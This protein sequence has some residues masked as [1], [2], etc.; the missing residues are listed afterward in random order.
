MTIL[1]ALR[2]PLLAMPFIGLAATL[3]WAA[4]PDADAIKV[5]QV[6]FLPGAVKFAVVPDGQ[7]RNFT[8]VRAGTDT[9]A[10][11][12]TLGPATAHA[13]SG[14][15]VR[16][17]P[18]TALAAPGRYQVRV[19]E[20]P[21]SA[22]FEIGPAVYGVVN[23][24]S[25]KAYYFN[26]ASTALA[27][28][29]AGAYA[30]PAGHPDTHVLVH[31]SA[32]SPGR[33]AGTA[34]ASP[35][36][37]YDAGD[38]NKY[39]VNSGISTYTLLAAYEDFPALF[40]AQDLNIPESGNDIPDLLDEALWN[41][42]WMLT[43]QDPA[44][45]GVYHKLTNLRFDGMVMPA[46]ATGP[47]YVVQKT[48]AAA[49]DF[50]AVM[51][52]ASRVFAP[53]ERQLPGLPARMR[54]AAQAAWRW[55]QA[56]PTDY[57][58]QPADVVTGEYGDKDVTDEF[59]WAAA[60]LFITTGDAAYY[61]AMG[62]PALQATV[63]SWSDVRGLAWMS[64]ARHRQRLGTVADQALI[65][66]RIDTLSQGL[67][68]ASRQSAYG[69]PMQGAD[70][71]WGSSAVAL[72]QA[73]VLLHGYRLTGKREYLDAAQAGLDYVLGRNA[74]GMSFV[75][76]IGKRSPQHPHHRPSEADSIAAPVPGWLVGGP[77][78]AQQDKKDC[79]VPYPSALPAKSYLDHACSYASNEVAINWNAPLVYVSAALQALTPAP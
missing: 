63:P 8:I 20:L 65:A 78:P 23:A 43:M 15:Q 24:A 75:T 16:L 12:G 17:A 70:Y 45:G 39:I 67:A 18:F 73:M 27:A 77:Q 60:E 30:R 44:D 48:T 21:D 68:A 7:A 3:A 41:L 28:T 38:Y 25:I 4:P 79:P 56:H 35:K 10:H 1:S 47:R 55:A 62:A 22:P 13:P 42:E 71:I 58:R 51:A 6:G 32:A 66:G 5:N 11:Q 33:P 74:V 31:A 61:Q 26:R 76:G 59:G 29:H 36:G 49:L 69:I 46:Q 53:Y 52:T 14:E 40:K 57:Y 2:L 54:A 50:A 19:A 9:V 34:I 37:W 72:N 64:L